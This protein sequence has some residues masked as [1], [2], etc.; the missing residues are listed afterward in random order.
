MIIM[1]K[2]VQFSKEDEEF[3]GSV[4]SLEFQSSIMQCMAVYL[5]VS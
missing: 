3:F 2:Q 4:G 1:D 5:E